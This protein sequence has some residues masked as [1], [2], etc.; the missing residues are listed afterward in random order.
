MPDRTTALNLTLAGPSRCQRPGYG[1]PVQLLIALADAL[2]HPL[3]RWMGE[4]PERLVALVGRLWR[5]ETIL[6]LLVAA[7][8]L[9]PLVMLAALSGA[10]V[11]IG[12]A[13][14]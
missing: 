9:L 4:L 5:P 12:R 11:E 8:A 2:L 13:H 1:W 6:V 3:R 14:V 7:V 10:T